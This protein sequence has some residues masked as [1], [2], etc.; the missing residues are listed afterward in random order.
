MYGDECRGD[1]EPE[2]IEPE[3]KYQRCLD[4]ELCQEWESDKKEYG[5]ERYIAR[6][7]RGNDAVFISTTEFL[8]GS[9]QK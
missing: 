5:E 2:D 7:F 8:E 6:Y 1:D 9:L 4:T 3:T